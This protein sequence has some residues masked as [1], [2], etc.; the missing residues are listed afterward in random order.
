VGVSSY[1]ENG[2]PGVEDP[3][4]LSVFGQVGGGLA[5]RL[6]GLHLGARLLYRVFNDVPPATEFQPYPLKGFR[7]DFFGGFSL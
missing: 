4:E 2:L 7:F 1:E 3:V 6:S 5:F